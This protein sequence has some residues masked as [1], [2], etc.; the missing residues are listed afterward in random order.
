MVSMHNHITSPK[1]NKAEIWSKYPISTKN[2]RIATSNCP[3]SEIH[4]REEMLCFGGLRSS[5]RQRS[6]I[7]GESGVEV[8]DSRWSCVKGFAF[9]GLGMERAL[10][11]S[12]TFLKKDYKI[13]FRLKYT[14]F[15]YFLKYI[16]LVHLLI[17]TF[18]SPF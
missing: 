13:K 1:L 7:W 15:S 8:S 2:Y 11:F 10:P 17:G 6:Q 14:F 4:E 12:F 5:H 16:I 9:W 3:S 18:H